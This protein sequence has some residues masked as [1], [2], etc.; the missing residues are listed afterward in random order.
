MTGISAN[1]RVQLEQIVETME[2]AWNA[3]DGPGFATPFA[4]DADFVNIRG[5]RFQSR[6]AIAAGHT[7]IF[8]SIYAG[9]SVSMSVE[10]ARLVRSDIALVHVDSR[11]SVPAGRLAGEHRARFSMTVTKE[12]DGWEIA[13]FHNTLQV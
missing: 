12:R 11:L 7:G 4:A 1:E 6:D 3:W 5:E 10:S 2:S 13:A 9:S 8:N